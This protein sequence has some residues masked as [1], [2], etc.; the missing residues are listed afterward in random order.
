MK[1]TLANG[2]PL[3]DLQI[4]EDG[5]LEGQT[6]NVT[7][8]PPSPGSIP[9]NGMVRLELDSEIIQ[10]SRLQ[11]GYEIKA[12]NN[13]EI[14]YLSE[15]YYKYGIIEGDVVT[16]TPSAIIDYLD[17]DWDFDAES[18]PDWEAIQKDD[19]RI[20]LAEEVRNSTS[21][22]EAKLFYTEALAGYDLQPTESATVMLN[23][24]KLL[25]SSEDIELGNETEI[26]KV[27][28]PGGP[29]ITSIPGNYVPGTGP[30]VESDD[31][32]AEIVIVTPNTGENMNYILPI[33]ITVIACVILGVGVVLIKK[34]VLK[35]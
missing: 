14:E 18:N 11:I 33:A 15:N 5:Q 26:V 8:L 25:T 1:L 13:S 28:K 17:S 29:N 23:V 21:I 9:A 6:G 31:G 4:T 16:I 34:K 3:V 12:T 24:S 22:D 20:S 7:Y 30:S 35:K 19:S 27:E 2:L 32:M 10:G